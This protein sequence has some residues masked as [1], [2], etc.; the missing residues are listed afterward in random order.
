MSDIKD[1]NILVD[2][3]VLYY[4]TFDLTTG[5]DTVMTTI[6]DKELGLAKGSLKFEAKP[7]IRDIEHCGALERKIVGLQRI[8]KWDVK[9]EAEILDFNKTVLEA[10][11]IKKVENTS[12]KFDVYE[13]SDKI[14][15]ADY[16]DLLIVG[17]KHGSSDPIIIHILNSYNAD[18]ISFETKDNDEASTA[19]TFNGCYKFNSNEKP[20]RV[21]MPKAV[22]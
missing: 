4:G 12:T 2:S 14:V 10:S 21:Y 16:K 7:E 9:A 6:K 17:Q 15:V 5:L 22:I 13:P 19:M 11:L 20:F 1:M 18:G 3:A 8:M